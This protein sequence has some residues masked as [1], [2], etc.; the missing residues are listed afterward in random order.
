MKKTDE[1]YL[2]ANA[3]A[4]FEK[5]HGKSS[6]ELGCRF[7]KIWHKPTFFP[8]RRVNTV[9]FAPTEK[10]GMA[11]I[12]EQNTIWNSVDHFW[13]FA[14]VGTIC[15]FMFIF[16]VTRRIEVIVFFTIFGLC[17]IILQMFRYKQCRKL[18]KIHNGNVDIYYPNL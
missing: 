17:E 10:I 11:F 1:N 2:L 14:L 18:E 6:T 4:W 16:V 13:I 12:K 9:V 8:F 5:K 15:M 7:V 3:Q